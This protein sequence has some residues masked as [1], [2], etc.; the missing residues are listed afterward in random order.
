MNKKIVEFVLNTFLNI[1][2]LLIVS[3]IFKKTIYI[4][5]SLFGLWYILVTIIIFLLN[6]TIKPIIVWLTLPI[7]ALT[8][9]I[10]YPFINVFILN[11]VD[12]ILGNHFNIQGLFIPF[13]LAILIAI[14][15]IV[16]SEIF[17][18]PITLKM[19]G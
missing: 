13:I 7:T 14:M 11:I 19:K 15:N 12:L 2:I 17:I 6:K 4:D 10:F 18:K 16:L 5:G 8:L 3:H 1:V 9:G